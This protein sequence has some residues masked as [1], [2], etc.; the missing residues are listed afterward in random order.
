MAAT[1]ISLIICI[2]NQDWILPSILKS[3]SDQRSA[4]RFEV[5]VC[6]DGS[7]DRGLELIRE[8]RRQNDIDI[9][10]VWQPQ[11]NV[12]RR[13]RSRNNGIRCSSG[14]ILI[15]ADGDMCLTPTF[16][17]DH[18]GAHQGSPSLVCGG[19][20]TIEVGRGATSEILEEAVKDALQ[21]KASREWDY[22]QS[23][24]NTDEPWMACIT[25]NCS[26]KRSTEI[27]FDERIRGWGSE[28][29]DFAIRAYRAGCKMVLLPDINAVHVVRDK[30]AHP[31]FKTEVIPFVKNK[32]L[33]RKL[34]PAGEM[35]H[36]LCLALYCRFD[37]AT[38]SW[39]A[40]PTPST[41]PVDTLLDKFEEWCLDNGE[42]LPYD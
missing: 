23:W 19:R 20:H 26:T 8:W 25:A 2:H 10:Y 3:I 5:I 7:S 28:D 42:A 16:I 4:V 31:A 18:W 24:K 40:N 37:G 13:S 6:D 12:S 41:Q 34:Y 1:A 17:A 35:I 38:N 9:R 30:G 21:V 15:C 27:L 36:S 32:L 33:P 14:E 22:Q 11:D 39:I 29:R